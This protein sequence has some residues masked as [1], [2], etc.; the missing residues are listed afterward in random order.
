MVEYSGR[1]INTHVIL[2][3]HVNDDYVCIRSD[4]SP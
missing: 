3:S 1:V 2:Y 4:Y